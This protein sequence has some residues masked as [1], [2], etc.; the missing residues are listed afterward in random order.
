MYSATFQHEKGS[1]IEQVQQMQAME[2][3]LIG[4]AREVEILHTE[5]RSAEKRLHGNFSLP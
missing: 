5:V 2:K 1:N 4:M 3:Q